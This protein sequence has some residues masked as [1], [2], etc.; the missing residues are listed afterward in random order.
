MMSVIDSRYEGRHS[1]VTK[2]NVRDEMVH[3]AIS[4]L[5]ERGVQGTSFAVLTE[6]TN[7]PRGSIYHHFPGGKNELIVDAVASIG[8]L[9]T[10]LIDAVDA[11]SPD[12]VVDVFVE[13]W[14]AVLL[15]SN[16]EGNCAVANTA[17]GAG[18]DESLRAASHQ[19]FEQ[20]QTALSRAFIRS[21]AHDATADDDAWVCIAAVEGALILARASRTDVAF[22]ALSRQLRNLVSASTR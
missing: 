19:V 21:G 3:G 6:T 17:L 5:A 20:W 2:R 7:T 12:E 1:Q 13:S 18:D 11:S 22:D 15:A 8:A 14:R 10:S 4:L 9:V 16:F